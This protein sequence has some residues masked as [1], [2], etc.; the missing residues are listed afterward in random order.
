ME[1][2]IIAVLFIV[3]LITI[4]NRINAG[5]G[6]PDISN[7]YPNVGV[8]II[9]DPALPPP[10]VSTFCSGILISQIHFLTAAHC[11]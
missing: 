8:L 2:N 11:A 4:S 7:E 1:K 9:F 5:V 6:E 10:N 3:L